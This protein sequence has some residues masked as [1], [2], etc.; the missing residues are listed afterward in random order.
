MLNQ[1]QDD[2][3][4]SGKMDK[5]LAKYEPFPGALKGHF[6]SLHRIDLFF[7][8]RSDAAQFVEEVED[9]DD[10]VVRGF[11][12]SFLH[13]PSPTQQSADRQDDS[14]AK[15]RMN[16]SRWGIRSGGTR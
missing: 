10:L 7:G 3:I 14:Y 8:N 6:Y 1:A 15:L 5:I 16:E 4:T 13:R 12:S 11:G 9:E 2:I